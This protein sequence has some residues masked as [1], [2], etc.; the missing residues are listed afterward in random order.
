MI[1]SSD[2][3]TIE[4]HNYPKQLSF[5]KDSLEDIVIKFKNY[6]DIKEIFSEISFISKEQIKEINKKFLFK[7][8]LSV[9]TLSKINL[10][11]NN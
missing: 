6:F 4:L 5:V 9:L 1:I 10:S 7:L 11:C 8:P 3:V 2:S